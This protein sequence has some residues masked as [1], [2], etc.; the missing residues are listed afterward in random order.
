MYR[1]ENCQSPRPR[2]PSDQGDEKAKAD[3]RTP[4]R[5]GIGLGI[6][7]Y[8]VGVGS[9][10]RSEIKDLLPAGSAPVASTKH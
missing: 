10:A 4:E 8:S 1:H 7:I 6:G 5:T 3:T 9:V 2:W